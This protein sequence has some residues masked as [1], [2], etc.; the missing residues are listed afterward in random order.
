[1]MDGHEVEKDMNE[2]ERENVVPATDDRAETAAG[3]ETTAI[4]K[5][6]AETGG[7][8]AAGLGE[9]ARAAGARAEKALETARLQA[10]KAAVRANQLI[11]EHP[12]AAVA[13]AVAI[14]AIAARA[15]PKGARKTRAVLPALPDTAALI[16]AAEEAP[17]KARLAPALEKAEHLIEQLSESARKAGFLIVEAHPFRYDSVIMDDR[18]LDGVEVYNANKNHDSHDYLAEL[19]AEKKHLI[20]TTGSD[21]HDP[22]DH[23]AAGIMTEEPIEDNETLLRVLRS[24]AY[25]LIHPD[26][27]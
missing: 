1:M 11:S 22:H 14:G 20:R 24:G 15:L 23:T 16:A 17:A 12:L 5:S 21:F 4:E 27:D 10:G 18:L 2:G 9:R 3:S 13:A 25:E 26:M 19:W 6:G 7:E 8:A